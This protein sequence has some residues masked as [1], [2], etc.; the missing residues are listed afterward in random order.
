MMMR[1]MDCEREVPQDQS[2]LANFPPPRDYE[3]LD[4][5]EHIALC[6]KAQDDG[7]S[8]ADSDTG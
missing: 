5:I 2:F 4:G 1:H 8:L 7:E 6:R 3:A